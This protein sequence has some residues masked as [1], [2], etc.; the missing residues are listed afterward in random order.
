M[1]TGHA[2]RLL[3]ALRRVVLARDTATRTD[4][5]V[6]TAFVVSQD[7]DAFAELVRRHGPMVLGVC[8]RVVGDFATAEDAFQAV[9]LVLAR[10]AGSIRPRSQVGNWLYGVAYRTAIKARTVLA[11]RRSREKQVETMPEPIAPT[12]AD[13]WSDLKPVIDE[14]LDRLPDKLRV[15]VVLCDLE[16]RPQRAVAR[17]LGIPAATL[18]T[19]IAAARRLLAARLSRRGVT[20][21]GG[22][23][24]VVL[25]ERASAAVVTPALMHGAVRAAEA[26]AA[27]AAVQSLVSAHAV[28]LSEGVMRMM[29]LVKLK[30]AAAATLAVL[31][32]C[33]GMGLGLSPAVAGDEPGA[34][35][36]AQP[37]GKQPGGSRPAACQPVDDPTFLNRLCLDLRGTPATVLE[38]TYFAGDADA[39]KRRKVT[40]WCIADDAVRTYIARKLGVPVERVR[41]IQVNGAAAIAVDVGAAPKV[42]ALAFS[43]DAEKLAARID[44]TIEATWL[45]EF[46]V[47]VSEAP[48]GPLLISTVK[49]DEG[50]T[51]SI[52]LNERN[53]DVTAKPARVNLNSIWVADAPA[54]LYKVVVATDPPV[55]V[56]DL[57][58]QQRD[59]SQILWQWITAQPPENPPAGQPFKIKLYV[60]PLGESDETFLRRVMQD[61]R[62]AAPSAIESKYFAEDKDPKKRE[63][64]LDLLL[65]DAAVQK[66]LGDDWRKRMLAPPAADMAIAYD[67]IRFTQPMVWEPYRINLPSD[68][69]I[70]YQ[71]YINTRPAAPP[72][73]RMVR[74]NQLDVLL[75]TLIA[76]KK[77]DAQI[78]EAVTLTVVGRLPTDAEKRLVLAA[79]AKASARKLAWLDAAVALA[80]SDEAK[81]HAESLNV[82]PKK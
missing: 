79:V 64:L 13:V 71:P 46:S 2:E 54:R 11:R 75:V 12:C 27:G 66:K 56:W 15:P 70:I 39:A 72:D 55:R 51:N 34:A 63:K 61:V 52:L 6:L 17:E 78:L 76:E 60:P 57:N 23:L 82:T 74:Q 36:P 47:R 4:A 65:K 67:T 9:F 42:S 8:R 44:A 80:D 68:S 77:T 18:A 40:D 35:K 48:T 16:G 10:R 21:S 59:E 53:F 73:P 38:Q 69:P 22:A 7:A 81:K 49:A 25:G 19:R 20:L 33:G 1:P 24:A 26:V 37:A 28:Q 41:L 31:A 62:G 5:Q 3:P 43:A 58:A 45:K 50:A 32:L 14:E 30:A 29:M